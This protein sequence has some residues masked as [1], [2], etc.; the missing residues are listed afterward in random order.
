MQLRMPTIMLAVFTAAS[1]PA[2]AQQKSYSMNLGREALA[3][4]AHSEN[5]DSKRSGDLV[6]GGICIGWIDGAVKAAGGSVSLVPEK[7][8]YCPPRGGTNG[9]YLAVFMKYIRDNPAKQHFPAIYLF[10]QSMAQ[11]FPCS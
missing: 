11:A 4:C 3:T 5:F 10:H 2:L 9:Q 1:G 8:D 7:P 6:A